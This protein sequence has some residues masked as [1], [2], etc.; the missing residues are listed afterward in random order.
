MFRYRRHRAGLTWCAALCAAGG[1]SLRAH[2]QCPEQWLSGVGTPGVNRFVTSLTPWDPDGAGPQHA[3]LIVGGDF[4]LAGG[5]GV[6]RLAAYEPATGGWATLGSAMGG[7]PH[8]FVYALTPMTSGDLAAGGYF[9]VAGGSPA[10]YIARWD[11]SA[12]H[13]LGAGMDA[14]VNALVPLPDGDLVAGGVFQNAGGVPASFIARWDGTDWHAMGSGLD[15]VVYALAVTP[16]GG[17]IAGG[18]F[19]TAGGVPALDVAR[20]DGTSWTAIGDGLD[21]QVNALTLLPS[22]EVVAGGSFTASAATP[23]AH[24]AR[25][26]GTSWTPLDVGT[27]GTVSALAVRGQDL[28]AAG[29]FTEA[30][31]VP[32]LRAAMWDGTTWH[33]LGDGLD[34]N[35]N[36]LAVIPNGSVFTAGFFGHAGG[37]PASRIAEWGPSTVPTLTLQP[38]NTAVCTGSDA[39]LTV[40][41]G[42]SPPLTYQWQAFDGAVWVDIGD[43]PVA[44]VGLASG[45]TAAELTISEPVSGARLRAQVTNLCAGTF[46]DEAEITVANC[47]DSLD[48]NNDTLSPD[49]ADIDD[50][51]SVFSGGT[52]SN[53]PSCGDIDFNNDG[54][55]PD[56]SDIDSLLLVF[57]GGPCL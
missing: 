36:A 32:A 19:F 24:I 10:S 16:G 53:D 51:L 11:G 9:L 56:T 50:F 35:A 21:G 49:T 22:G 33:A 6:S 47:C 30:G 43:G 26:D 34:F 4:T 31:G 52:C 27:N 45:A 37:A 40:A 7:L 5:M 15:G 3:L 2:G 28:F 46:S 38:G 41:A 25:F 55:F 44:G 42:G 13:P 54:F 12:W 29:S 39:H 57:S 8:P 20:W 1:L 14:W 18:G 17:V 48:F 23:L